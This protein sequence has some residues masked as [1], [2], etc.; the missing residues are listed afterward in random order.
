MENQQIFPKSKL[1]EAIKKDEIEDKLKEI[2]MAERDIRYLF[3][4]TDFL[5]MQFKNH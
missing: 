4:N 2:G 3:N 1:K 5:L